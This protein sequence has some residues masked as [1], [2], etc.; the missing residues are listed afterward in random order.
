LSKIIEDNKYTPYDP[1]TPYNQ[2]TKTGHE[3]PHFY[4]IKNQFPSFY[5]SPG[6]QNK[7]GQI[8]GI[9]Q[10]VPQANFFFN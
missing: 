8:M 3:I 6:K 4:S 1:D 9:N 2:L 10:S 5:Y 7:E